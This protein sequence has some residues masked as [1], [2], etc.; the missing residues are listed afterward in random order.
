MRIVHLRS[1]DYARR[2]GGWVYNTRL[3]VALAAQAHTFTEIVAP[4]AFPSIGAHDAA[5]LA[6]GFEALPPDAILVTDHLHVA[7]LIPQ[8][9]DRR[10]S[11][12][13]VFHH[14]T[15]IEDEANGVHPDAGEERR[16]LAMCDAVI[17]TSDETAAYIAYHHGVAP[18][19]IVLAAPGNDVVP[20][21][22]GPS[23]GSRRILTV[24]AAVAR[25]RYPYLV[26]VASRLR[27]A[28]WHW[29]I[30]GDLE[31][32][33]DHVTAL[34]SAIDG[35]GLAARIR[36]A[37]ALEDGALAD[38]WNRSGLYVAASLY[39]G[40]GMAVSE[41]L[42]HGVPV[43]TT[44]SG[45]VAGWAGEAVLLAPDDD[46]AAFAGIIDCVLEDAAGQRR[47]GDLA[48]AFGSSLPGWDATFADIA[49]R[50]AAACLGA[51]VE[52]AA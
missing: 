24:G 30:V 50:I 23:R 27:S 31:R 2:S 39:E 37:G 14:S 3:A 6:A 12:A 16:C 15:T 49:P 51:G 34:R 45:A 20:R 10:F 44:A 40:Y 1:A 4:V 21:A 32:D 46:A 41:A 8:L 28:D 22:S 35:A 43:V 25:K 7:Q 17:V 47:L 18:S 5:R 13:A 19:R 26:G 36:L 42:R 38:E 9:A 48:F 29:T 33:P 11:L 52:A